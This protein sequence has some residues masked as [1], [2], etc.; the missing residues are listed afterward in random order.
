MSAS[1][2]IGPL[3][4]PLGPL[5]LLAAAT[6]GLV[7]GRRAGRKRAAEVESVLLR[8]LLVA[9]LAARLAFV[10]AWRSS[11]LEQPLSMLDIRDGGWDPGIGLGAAAL[12][13]LAAARRHPALRKA[14]AAGALTTATLW[15]VASVWL[16][17]SE[18]A[19]RKPMPA[20]QLA[21]LE[22]GSVDL[23]S[24]AGKPT[25]VNLW[26]TWCPPCRR[27][28]PLLQ[29]AQAARPQ[30]NFV[31]L[32]QGEDRPQVERFLREQRLPLKNV[33]LDRNLQAGTS[34]DQRALPT[35]LFFDADGRLVSTRLG[36]LSDAVLAQ[37]LQALGAGSSPATASTSSP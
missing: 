22:G 20:L 36:E 35:T 7:V 30:V 11:Y 37:R 8:M 13:G 12:Y 2:Q 10:W 34:F 27:E 4:V 14:L 32:N 24:F 17:T 18:S 3:A 9:L 31:F 25:V 5:L 6:A 21:A 33:L 1:L 19:D 16:W 23:R 28:M 29:R 15:G 26:A